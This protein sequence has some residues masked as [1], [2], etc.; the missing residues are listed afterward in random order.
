[1][2]KKS[3]HLKRHEEAKFWEEVWDALDVEP[4][5]RTILRRVVTE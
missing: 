5:I 2:K 1:M 3:S 4:E